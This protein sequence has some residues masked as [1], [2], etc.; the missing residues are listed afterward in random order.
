MVALPSSAA[1]PDVT[2]LSLPSLP[3]LEITPLEIS[4]L[5]L[6]Q[7]ASQQTVCDGALGLLVPQGIS[8][9]ANCTATCT[10]C[11]GHAFCSPC[12]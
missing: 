3:P 5:E 2:A 7:K 6:D 11:I 12:N 8:P 1:L 10:E 4:G 9:T